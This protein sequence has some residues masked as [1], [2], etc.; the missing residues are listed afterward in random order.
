MKLKE[1]ITGEKIDIR[2]LY[3]K[4]EGKLAI[5]MVE[6]LDIKV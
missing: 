1:Y 3:F 4:S 5:W 6:G 2:D